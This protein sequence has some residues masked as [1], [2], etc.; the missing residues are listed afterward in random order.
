MFATLLLRVDR[1]LRTDGIISPNC[2]SLA[3]SVPKSSPQVG[4]IAELGFGEA[5]Q[6]AKALGLERTLGIER[7]PAGATRSE[8]PLRLSVQRRMSA[9]RLDKRTMPAKPTSARALP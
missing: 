2:K 5:A 8:N 6:G 4:A 1:N 3:A 9:Q 7:K